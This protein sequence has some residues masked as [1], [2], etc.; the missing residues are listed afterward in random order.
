V[1]EMLT[2]FQQSGTYHVLYT[3]PNTQGY[4][5][6]RFDGWTRQPEK[7][8]PVLYTNSSPTYAAFEVASDSGGGGDDDG[9]GN[10]AIIAIGVIAVL[11]IGAGVVLARRRRTAYER[12]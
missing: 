3:E 2:R 11:A 9:G 1:H 12:E 6:G 5:K 4:V 8:G 7:T 10:G